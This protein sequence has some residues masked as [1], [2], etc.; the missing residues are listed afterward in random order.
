LFDFKRLDLKTGI[1][2]DFGFALQYLVHEL[3]N[4]LFLIGGQYQVPV[5]KGPVPAELLIAIKEDSNRRS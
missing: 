3:K 5:M 4:Q 2:E 1:L